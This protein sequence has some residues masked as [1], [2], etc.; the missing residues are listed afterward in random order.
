M[1]NLQFTKVLELWKERVADKASGR[2]AR[3]L[4]RQYAEILK[5]KDPRDAL[6]HGMCFW[7]AENLS[8]F[9]TIRVKGREVIPFQFSQKDLGDIASKLGAI[10]FKIR[11]PDG[12]IDHARALVKQGGYI[13]RRAVAVLTRAAVDHDGYPTDGSNSG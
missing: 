2:R 10:N 11:F 5:L 12:L 8:H 13:S 7:S 9:S 3:V 4:Q 1:N 6:A